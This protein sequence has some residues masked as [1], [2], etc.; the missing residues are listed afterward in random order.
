M[1]AIAVAYATPKELKILALTQK[2][3]TTGQNQNIREQIAI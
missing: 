3:L 1:I 2:K